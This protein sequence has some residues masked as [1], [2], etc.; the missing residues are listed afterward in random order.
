MDPIY[1]TDHFSIALLLVFTILLVSGAI[2]AGQLLGAY[3]KRQSGGGE[4]IGSVVGATL[5]FLAFLLAF[6]FNMAA[7]RYDN[8]KNLLVEELNVIHVTYQRAGLLDEAMSTKS[9]KLLKE[10]VELRVILARDMDKTQE[11]ILRSEEILNTLW[12]DVEE[13]AARQTLSMPVSLYSQSLN[14]MMNMLER[15]VVVGLHFRIPGAIWLGLYVLAFLAMIVVGYQFGQSK[16]RQWLVSLVLALAFSSII[17]L[18]ADL[19][20]AN[21]GFIKMNQQP[22]FEFQKKIEAL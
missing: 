13:L 17:L 11:L 15:R 8:R 18:I 20:R 2:L 9:R 19:D 12:L 21:E 4:S 22:V 14:E 3:M 16:H 10:Y 7:G 5:G 1:W 6:T